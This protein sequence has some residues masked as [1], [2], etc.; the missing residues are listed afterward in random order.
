MNES[1]LEIIRRQ[2]R[3]AEERQKLAGREQG[4][5]APAKDKP[6][7]GPPADTAAAPTAAGG[8]QVQGKLG[9][10]VRILQRSFQALLEASRDSFILVDADDGW[11]LVNHHLPEWLGYT[12]EESQGINL[13]EVFEP[14]D[15]EKLQAIFPDLLEGREPLKQAPFLLR[16]KKGDR[17][18]V[19][20]SSY[21]WVNEARARVAYLVLEDER[22]RSSLETQISA[23]KAFIDAVMRVGT[24]PIFQL[25]RDGMILDVNDAAAQ[26]LGLDAAEL[27]NKRLREYVVVNSRNDFDRMLER[28]LALEPPTNTFCRFLGSSGVEFG[29]RTSFA[30]VS[31]P[32]GAVYR[33]LLTLD[34][35]QID[36]GTGQP[37][38]DWAAYGQMTPAI[39]NELSHFINGSLRGLSDKIRESGS[40]SVPYAGLTRLVQ[41]M[42][43]VR[44]L[45]TAWA[46]SADFLSVRAQEVRL[47]DLLRDALASRRPELERWR[48]RSE[49]H[50][51]DPQLESCPC[52]QVLFS[53]ILHILQSCVEEVREG[54]APSKLNIRVQAA[55]ERLETT[56]VYELAGH[57]PSTAVPEGSSGGSEQLRLKNMELR[58]A[59]RLLESIGGTIVLESIS[60]TQHAVRMSLNPGLIAQEAADLSTR[61]HRKT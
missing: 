56:F 51:S 18:P 19:L 5:A 30:G 55:G 28:A 33:V 44:A 6:R 53:I 58:A 1:P 22:Q 40:E 59:Q 9:G 31:D 15:V 7:S 12:R 8:A 10:L 35:L 34:H 48:I 60:G 38:S 3:E 41:G 29:A 37:I 13:N 26:I 14:E 21:S 25:R 43:R 49:L 11:E 17:V 42:D 20:I 47:G 23:S 27:L 2:I 24:I 57:R 16:G 46:E 36:A 61:Q 52:P 4:S 50:I 32:R 39:L 45:L 54:G